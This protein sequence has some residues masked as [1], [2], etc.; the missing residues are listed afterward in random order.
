MGSDIPMMKTLLYIIIVIMGFVFSVI[1]GNTI[2]SEASIIGSLLA[3]GYRKHELICHYMAPAVHYQYAEIV[4]IGMAAYFAVNGLH[5]KRIQKI[6][7]A[8]ALKNRE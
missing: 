6:K 2:E 7:M 3:L 4:L 8:D 5:R 1:A